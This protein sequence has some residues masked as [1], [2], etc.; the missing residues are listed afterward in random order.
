MEN[1]SNPYGR[2]IAKVVGVSDDGEVLIQLKDTSLIRKC[3]SIEVIPIDKRKVSP[4]QRRM[5]WQLIGCIAE[6]AGESKSNTVK[7]LFNEMMKCEFFTQAGEEIGKFSLSDAPMSLVLEYQKFLINFVVENDIQTPIPLYN[8]ANDAYSYVY[9]CLAKKKCCI[10]RRSADL[11]HVNRVGMGRN[12]KT[13]IHEGLLAYPLC[14]IHHSEAHTM[15]DK[16]FVDKYKLPN[17]IK[18]DRNLCQVL[19]VKAT[20]D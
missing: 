2:Q 3:G 20:A 14:R 5:C 9:S 18:L 12:R 6:W 19:G 11:H 7:D 16:E 10:C 13:I 8:Y 15:P 4:Q 1:S 17:P